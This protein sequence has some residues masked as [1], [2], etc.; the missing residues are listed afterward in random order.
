MPAANFGSSDYITLGYLVSTYDLEHDEDYMEDIRAQ[1]L[2]DWYDDNPDWNLDE[3][4]E[5][6]PAEDLDAPD[7]SSYVDDILARE[8]EWM[9]EDA[10]YG[11]KR[12]ISDANLYYFSVELESGYYEGYYLDISWNR[13]YLESE[14]QKEELYQEIAKI[15]EILTELA[16][17]GWRTVSSTCYSTYYA[18]EEQT[19][20]DISEA[21]AAMVEE[22]QEAKVYDSDEPG[23]DYY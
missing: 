4:G 3:N 2:E 22:V 16:S 14:N 15:G 19:M 12:L 9:Y 5:E 18:E 6:I 7:L 20:Q 1:A 11:A 8:E 10:Y 13:D 21:L 17:Y 23:Q